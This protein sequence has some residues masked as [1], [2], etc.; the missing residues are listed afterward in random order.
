MSK[1]SKHH[2][3][4]SES[5]TSEKVSA[6]ELESYFARG[7]TPLRSHN[8]KTKSKSKSPTSKNELANDLYIDH[9]DELESYFARGRPNNK[10]KSPS[11]NKSKGG[12]RSTL[13]KSMKKK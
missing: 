2:R 1:K 9:L 12:K 4:K 8:N 6:N 10:S 11:P 13:K 3:R 7:R 5:P